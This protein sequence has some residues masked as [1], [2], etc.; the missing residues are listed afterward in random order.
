MKKYIEQKA[1]A[2]LGKAAAFVAV[3]FI[4]V[5][6]MGAA[7][8]AD[9]NRPLP[10]DLAEL[11]GAFSGE[12]DVGGKKR[13]VEVL[14]H[15]APMRSFVITLIRADK[16]KKKVAQIFHAR[17]LEE[18]TLGLISLG[19]SANQGEIDQEMP[20]SALMKITVDKKNM[21]QS[22][23]IGP[24]EGSSL[25]AS[26]VRLQETSK[27]IQVS[28]ELALGEYVGRD[29]RN[30]K[31]RVGQSA[32]GVFVSGTVPRIGLSNDYTFN[33]DLTGV[34]VLRA[35]SYDDHFRRREEQKIT[36][37]FL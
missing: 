34:G 30:E 3:V 22:I 27:I 19:L 5:M 36:A 12:Q 25:L 13:K 20:P 28:D 15:G 1:A 10:S 2:T 16:R 17:I 23:D 32:E 35:R 9:I 6:A 31:I 37:L 11:Q 8:L 26:P 4:I 21:I 24:Q 18:K 7:A 29:R 14:I 33:F